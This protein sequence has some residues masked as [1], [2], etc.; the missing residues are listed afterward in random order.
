[1]REECQLMRTFSSTTHAD[2][3]TTRDRDAMTLMWKAAVAFIVAIGAGGFVAGS[4]LGDP[5]GPPNVGDPVVV[6][7]DG[8]PGPS[9][10]DDN[11]SRPADDDG[12]DDRGH[13]DDDGDDDLDT[14]YHEPDDLFDDDDNSGPGSDDDRGRDDDGGG[15]DDNSGHGSDDSG[16]DDG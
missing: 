15:D 13:G 9:G 16:G 5:G 8:S 2:L 1:M 14:V 11:P 10:A 6:N 7:G 12:T 4:V 3:G